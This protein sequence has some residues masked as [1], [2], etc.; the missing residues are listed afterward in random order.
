LSR[1]THEALIGPIEGYVS[2][3]L[4]TITPRA[5]SAAKELPFVHTAGPKPKLR[6]RDSK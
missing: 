1:D 5:L 2:K 4:E 6:A 3:K